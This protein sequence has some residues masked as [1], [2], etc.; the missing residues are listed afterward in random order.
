MAD[1]FINN[2]QDGV[3][4]GLSQEF[5][6]F[7][8]S[9]GENRSDLDFLNTKGDEQREFFRFRRP[10]GDPLT[11][12]FN[13][14]FVTAP[15]LP[16]TAGSTSFATAPGANR[17]NA[18]KQ[19]LTQ[20]QRILGL[21]NQSLFPREVQ[22]WLSGAHNDQFIPILTNRSVGSVASD[23][24]LNT[25]DYAE[26]YNRYK[27]VLGTSAKDSRI[28]GTMT[29]PYQEDS[30]LTIL[31]LHK[32]WQLYIEKV[33]TG[34]CTPGGV[35]L[36]QDMMSNEKRTIDYM[37]SIYLFSV[38]PDGETLNYWCKF[39]G[40]LPVKMPW[41]EFTSEDGNHEVKSSVPIEYQ[42]TYKEDLTLD[43]LRDF[44]LTSSFKG[45]EAMDKNLFQGSVVDVEAAAVPAN[46]P[47][48]ERIKNVKEYE[49]KVRYRLVF[50]DGTAGQN[51]VNKAGNS[52]A[53]TGPTS[54][55]SLEKQARNFL[56]G[57]GG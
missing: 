44:N 56:G 15:E 46:R 29:I 23:E 16:I 22:E 13:Y 7:Y 34:E 6:N 33:Y 48:V 35:L 27:I 31:K 19:I 9:L 42:F 50:P 25:I 51:A 43:V 2:M 55:L 38:L 18:I 57:R 3:Y 54:S 39:T 47:R 1:N 20:N 21:H 41:S 36:S 14:I 11:T 30:D 4:V 40:C 5:D 52:A 45:L 28:S 24:I 37:V 53:A 12:G 17:A 10:L 49:N 32:L 8:K 26:T